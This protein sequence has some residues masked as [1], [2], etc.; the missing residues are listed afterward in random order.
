MYKIDK[1]NIENLK[2]TFDTNSINYVT[3]HLSFNKSFDNLFILKNWNI[4]APKEYI[5]WNLYNPYEKLIYVIKSIKND[6][7]GLARST[8]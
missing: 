7:K 8:S 6:L 2:Y 4:D 5:F 1:F 3:E